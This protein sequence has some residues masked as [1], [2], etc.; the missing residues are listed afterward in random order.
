[1]NNVDVRVT[2]MASLEHKGDTLYYAPTNA[3]EGPHGHWLNQAELAPSIQSEGSIPW[4]DAKPLEIAPNSGIM[5][6][7]F[8]RDRAAPNN[9]RNV[10]YLGVTVPAWYNAPY[11]TLGVVPP[12]ECRLVSDV[13]H[14]A[15]CLQ[16]FGTVFEHDRHVSY[17]PMTEPPG[18]A[19][20]VDDERHLAIYC[21]EGATERVFCRYLALLGKLF[22]QD[23]LLGCDMHRYR[24]FCL[25]L[26]P[27]HEALPSDATGSPV[28]GFYSVTNGDMRNNLSCVVTVPVFHGTGMG[29]LLI[30]HSYMRSRSQNLFQGPE[31]PLSSLGR[32]AYERY[33]DYVVLRAICDAQSAEG[34]STIS[35]DFISKSTGLTLEDTFETLGRLGVV[36]R[37]GNSGVPRDDFCLA[38]QDGHLEWIARVRSRWDPLLNSLEE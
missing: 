4:S 27:G 15:G 12:P 13:W 37:V 2:H 25:C 17:C 9:I 38:L 16:P 18:I 29:T 10:T 8:L 7:R 31:R 24:F 32:T 36:H 23:K 5:E 35:V 21:V 20:H 1:M 11:H 34:S 3:T 30:H 26:T 28:I 19:V 22:L 6:R 14:C 33:W